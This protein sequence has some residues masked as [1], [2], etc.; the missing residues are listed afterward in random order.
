LVG[1]H[2]VFVGEN[3]LGH[4]PGVVPVHAEFAD[5]LAS[6]ILWTHDAARLVDVDCIVAE[7]PHQEDGDGEEG[8]FRA[9]ERAQ[10]I[11]HAEFRH[12][13]RSTADHCLEDVRDDTAAVESC[14]NAADL[15]GPFS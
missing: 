15:D 2:T 14:I 4:H 8:R 12:V 11:G 3:A 10:E 6:Q 7:R 1:L 9:P 13:V 5:P